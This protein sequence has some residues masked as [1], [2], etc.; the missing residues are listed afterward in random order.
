VPQVLDKLKLSGC[1]A[2][3]AMQEYD[4]DGDGGINFYEF[5]KMLASTDG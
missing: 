1:S 3:L 2:Q 5:C 4:E